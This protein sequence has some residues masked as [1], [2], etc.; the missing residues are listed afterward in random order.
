MKKGLIFLLFSILI[1]FSL[2]FIIPKKDYQIITAI[3]NKNSNN[4]MNIRKTA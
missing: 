4:F 3:I 2:S 1:I